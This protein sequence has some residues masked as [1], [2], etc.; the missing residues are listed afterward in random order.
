MAKV[1]CVMGDSGAGKTTSMRN[2]DPETTYYIDCD[3]KGLSWKGWKEQYIPSVNYTKTDFP[4]IVQSLLVWL[5]GKKLDEKKQPITAGLKFKV[6]VI[7]TIN[8]IMVAD[9][10]RRCKEKGYDKWQDLAQS[11]YDIVDYALTMRDDLTVIFVAHTQTDHDDNGF[12]FTRI[13]TSGRKL[14]KITLESKFGTV[15]L[16][17]T[18]DG[19]H[20]FETQA[21]L[22]TAKTPFGAFGEDEK[23]IDNDIAEVI[24]RLEDF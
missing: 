16:A 12:M 15:L 7:D 9:E 23:E 24:K 1:L 6:V 19:R 3:K 22:S 21:N 10:M 4:Q 18:I 13:K 2:L 11:I 5:N 14:D 17:K 8:G 20:V